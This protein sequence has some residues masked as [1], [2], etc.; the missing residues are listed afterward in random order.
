[1]GESTN[2]DNDRHW[3]ESGKLELAQRTERNAT[4]S[5]DSQEKIVWRIKKEIE[6]VSCF[7]F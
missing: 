3:P 2:H 7:Q 1:M 5:R 6:K 4:L